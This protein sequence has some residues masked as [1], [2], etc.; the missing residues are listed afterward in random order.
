MPFPPRLWAS[1]G[2]LAGVVGG[3]GTATFVYAR[4]FSYMTSDPSACANCHVMGDV[5]DR[6]ARSSH[7]IVAAC[8]DCHLPAGLAGKLWTKGENGMRHSL[9]FTF[10][11]F[12]EPI[13]I[14]PRDRAIAEG[15]CRRCHGE[16]TV[17]IDR[18]SGRDEPLA[19]AR[20]HG[21]AGHP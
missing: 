12:P 14:V 17:A 2:I 5:Y 1:L 9:A 7:R 8:N 6:W 10:G 20:C 4:G 18:T 16:M 3:A 15:A 21:T 11:G 19:C 13:R